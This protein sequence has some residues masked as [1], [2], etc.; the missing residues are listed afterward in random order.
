MAPF[1]GTTATPSI[2]KD[3][4]P[5]PPSNNP[6]IMCEKVMDQPNEAVLAPIVF[7][8]AKYKAARTL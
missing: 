3:T 5:P 4:A 2:R 1:L 8:N 7:N 6:M